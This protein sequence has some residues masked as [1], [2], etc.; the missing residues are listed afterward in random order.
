MFRG[1]FESL[2]TIQETNTVAVP[3]PIAVGHSENGHYFLVM[4]YLKLKP[5]LN[6]SKYANCSAELGNKLADMHLYNLHS[7]SG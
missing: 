4:E 1:E 3:S 6:S 7:K 5:L 2:K